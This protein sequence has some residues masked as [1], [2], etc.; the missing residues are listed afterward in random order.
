MD[1][2]LTAIKETNKSIPCLIN[3]L[4]YIKEQ[5]TKPFKDI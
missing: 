3:D 4:Q 2:V 1:K 5:I